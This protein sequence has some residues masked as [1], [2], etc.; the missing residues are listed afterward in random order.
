MGLSDMKKLLLLF[1]IWP[2]VLF[3]AN[4][5][6]EAFLGTNGI[7]VISNPPNGKII[8]DGGA[9]ASSAALVWTNNGA[10]IYPIVHSNR[11]QLTT[12]QIF[13]VAIKATTTN[14]SLGVGAL[15]N[16]TGT[17]LNVAIGNGAMQ[18]SPDAYQD[19]A[20][21]HGVLQYDTSTGGE[22]TAVGF[23]AMSSNRSG[24]FNAA[25]GEFALRFNTN[26]QRNT[27]IGYTA[28]ETNL[29]G[30]NNTYVGAQA[31]QSMTNGS[32][33]T[34]VGSGA[35]ILSQGHANSVLGYGGFPFL[36]FGSNNVAVGARVSPNFTNGDN[37]TFIGAQANVGPGFESV[38]NSTA[39]GF[40]SVVTRANQMVFGSGVSNYQFRGIDYVF[41][42][43]QG[44]AGTAL[45]NNGSGVLG[46][47][48][49][50]F[51]GASIGF[52]TNQ[53]TTNVALTPVLGTLWFNGTNFATYADGAN[54]NATRLGLEW[55]PLRRSLRAGEISGTG[56]N[57]WGTTN[58]GIL[59]VAF[60]SN[61][62]AGGYGSSV[63]GG[64]GNLIPTNEPYSVIVGGEANNFLGTGARN[65]IGG[66]HNNQIQ[67]LTTNSLIVGGSDHII[68]GSLHY[69]TIG[70]GQQNLI[71]RIYGTISG[72]V[73][74]DIQGNYGFIG[75]GQNNVAGTAAG[76]THV[77]IG[78]GN[79]NQVDVAYGT[80]AGGNNNRINTSGDNGTIGG[81]VGNV[82]DGPNSTIS[83]GVR[84]NIENL[85]EYALIAGGLTNY[86]STASDA[87][88]SFISGGVSNRI[89]AVPMAAIVGFFQTNAMAKSILI[90]S[91]NTDNVRVSETNLHLHGLNM[92]LLMTNGAGAGKVL[93][94]DA[95]GRG[96]W[97]TGGASL[98]SGTTNFMNLSVQAAKLPVT[99]YAG[100]DAGWQAWETVYAET[101]AEGARATLSA[102]WQ[103]MVPP[104]YAT[105]SL[106]LLI[107][108]SLLNT[109]GP[110]TS[111][112]VWGAS[113]LVARSGTTNNIHT[114]LFGSVVKGSN[115]WIAK[116]D[117]TNYVTNLVL[118][119]D[120][121]SLLM[122]RDVAVL[123]LERYVTED[124]YGGA[125]ALHGLQAEYTRP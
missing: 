31:G 70:G 89:T 107:N 4:P 3:G 102:A 79:L 80:I 114:N 118:N 123:K 78:G 81:G 112:V 44:A 120:T 56:S 110:N 37:N 36:I 17:T 100:I 84:N 62:L 99:N 77:V 34:L 13:G 39:I 74:N 91:T 22:N 5:P 108:Y 109:N 59:S 16:N 47:G 88:F 111:N 15:S 119:L 58:L 12:N 6:Y 45:T 64:R 104:D 113:V 90:G 82:A 38:T 33:N 7:V 18:N 96:T 92:A 83:G 69:A 106:K 87:S 122:P 116:Y 10:V 48:S 8:I 14:T 76:D 68:Q 93:T 85:A 50:S 23:Q 94:S 49:V 20:V 24:Y 41:P 71:R 86:I 57:Y 98:L 115:D 32:F 35:A 103:F 63:L 40:T 117:G 42:G 52:E 55:V 51:S 43:S 27:A 9:V 2:F 46:W 65:F 95:N 29:D 105:N 124:T 11:M 19:V 61:N 28:G 30:I 75:G 67:T 21:G 54:T 73:G 66:G 60:G 25:L 101:N 121:S 125:V 26:G 1:L 97:G 53:Y 72:G